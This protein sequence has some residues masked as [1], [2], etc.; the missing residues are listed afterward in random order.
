DVEKVFKLAYK[1]KC[2]GITVYRYG[3]K[4]EQVLY[5]GSVIGKEVGERSEFISAEADY[6]GGHPSLF[7][8]WC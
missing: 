5:I 2:K 7:C 4:K 3:S 1:L 8:P 6:A